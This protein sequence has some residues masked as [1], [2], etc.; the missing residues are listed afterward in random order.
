MVHRVVILNL[1]VLVSIQLEV[2]VGLDR[3]AT[4]MAAAAIFS[5]PKPP[6]YH[7][8]MYTNYGAP[9]LPQDLIY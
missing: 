1:A 9:N 5:C 8:K 4:N 7:F 3:L 2:Q 6:Q